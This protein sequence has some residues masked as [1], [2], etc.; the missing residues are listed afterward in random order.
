MLYIKLNAT[1]LTFFD[2]ISDEHSDIIVSRSKGFDGGIESAE[3]II[4]LTPSVLA[5]ASTILTQ[6]ISYMKEKYTTDKG[7]QTEII[8][9]KKIGDNNFKILLKSSGI[10]DVN[11][12]V[13][14]LLKEIRKHGR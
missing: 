2:R 13:Q 12:E 11:E 4:L 8:I 9:E 6:I 3:V 1:D 14:R 5:C 10:S 7:N